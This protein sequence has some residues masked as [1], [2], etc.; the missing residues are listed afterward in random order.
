MGIQ[1][2]V[3]AAVR[4]VVARRRVTF[5]A[6][7]LDRVRPG[8]E[9]KVDLNTLEIANKRRCVIGQLVGDF[10]RS[11]SLGIPSSHEAA[12]KFGVVSPDDGEL[13]PYLNEAWRNEIEVR[14][15]ADELVGV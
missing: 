3:R 1:T 12:K 2:A 11:D 7:H 9:K 13:Y 4:H 5:G 14:R 6:R 10:D 15:G 8:W